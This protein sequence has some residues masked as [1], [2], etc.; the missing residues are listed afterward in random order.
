MQELKIAVAL[1]PLLPLVGFLFTLLFGKRLGA[2]A[3]LVP[4]A[5]VT[6]SAVLCVY[7]FGWVFRH[8]ETPS[9]GRLSPGSRAVASP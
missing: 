2:R 9:S 6:A 1:I 8:Q 7:V 4:V 5:F 3:H